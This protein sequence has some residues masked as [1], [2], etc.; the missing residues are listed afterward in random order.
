MYW[1]SVLSCLGCSKEHGLNIIKK[2]LVM[3]SIK[4]RSLSLYWVF[5]LST[6]FVRKNVS[7]Y[8]ICQ[9]KCVLGAQK[10]H[11]LETIL[12]STQNICFG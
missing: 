7:F 2:K 5:K 8:L 10:N 4:P 6:L 3:Y 11:L 1:V 12:L 9:F